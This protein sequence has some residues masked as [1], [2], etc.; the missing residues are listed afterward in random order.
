MSLMAGLVFFWAYREWLSGILLTGIFLLPVLSLL[1][2]LPAMFTCKAQIHCPTGVSVGSSASITYTLQC[3]FPP[4]IAAGRAKV[5]FSFGGKGVRYR[6]GSDLPTG[7]C[8]ALKIVSAR[9]W[10][11]DY[12]G[13]FRFPVS[14][15]EERTVL[16]RP[17]PQEPADIPNMSRFLSTHARPKPGGGYAENHELRLYRP[18]DSLRQI[19]WKLSAKAGDLIIREP[20]DIQDN[21]ALLTLSLS[22][23]PQQLDKKLGQLLWVS[24]YLTERGI[25]HRICCL[26]GS[27]PKQF[28]V[29]NETETAAAIDTLLQC[30]PATDNSFSFPKAAW[31][32]HIGGDANEG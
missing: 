14:R 24:N 2:S 15:K 7:H 19:H 12:L 27:G 4:S 18:G 30:A 28:F 8:G 23:T 26:T 5:R 11:C 13:L 32:Y 6:F 20:M 17:Q 10:M 29:K 9:I 25:S 16:V 1:L 21:A 3:T 22:G 31:R